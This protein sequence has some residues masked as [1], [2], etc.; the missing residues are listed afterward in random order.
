[1][2]NILYTALLFSFFFNKIAAQ[3]T[4]CGAGYST[5][6]SSNILFPNNLNPTLDGQILPFG[7]HIIAIFQENGIWQCAGYV[8]WNG[9]SVS[10]VV[11]GN[12][13]NLPGYAANEPYQY[14]VQLPNGCLIDSVVATYD[15]SG[16]YS[17]PGYFLDG[18]LSKLS[19]FHAFS[20]AWVALDTVNGLCGGNT[21]VIEA[22]V[23]PLGA[24]NTFLWSN[25]DTTD[26]ISNLAT[27]QYSVTVTNAYGCTTTV[28]ATVSNVPE[29]SVQLAT[30]Y[31][32]SEVACQSV[33][34]VGGGTAPFTFAWSNGQSGNV[35]TNLTD[36]DFSVTV[37]DANSCTTV[38]TDHCTLSAVSDM[39]KLTHFSL[40][41]NP[42]DGLLWVHVVFSEHV[43]WSVS[44]YDR[45]G[46]KIFS[47][48]S[49]GELLNLEI[50]LTSSPSGLCFVVLQSEG[51]TAM[52]KLMLF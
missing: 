14:V 30:E 31:L 35:A 39:P 29:M 19:G 43:D 18:G 34:S 13:S 52:E 1:M 23:S 37:T 8:Q 6:S 3:P 2:Q 7:G 41:P 51:R 21:A 11:N 50:D 48:V 28:Q 4:F 25:G 16:I 17:N 12:D 46:K 26:A 9:N 20:R 15:V 22:A 40:S 49:E 5:F 33:A 38:Q 36:G 45:Q 47:R 10:M 42:S 44:V 27:G 32:F 24:P